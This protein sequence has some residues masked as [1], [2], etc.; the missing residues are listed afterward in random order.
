MARSNNL[1]AQLNL[2]VSLESLGRATKFTALD[3]QLTEGQLKVRITVTLRWGMACRKIQIQ[4]PWD[5]RRL[6][7]SNCRSRLASGRW[8]AFLR[9]LGHVLGC[10]NPWLATIRISEGRTKAVKVKSSVGQVQNLWADQLRNKHGQ[11][12]HYLSRIENFGPLRSWIQSPRWHLLTTQERGSMVSGL[13]G[14][15]VDLYWQ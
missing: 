15:S 11:E 14:D 3:I 13:S 5:Q 2:A 9:I 1:I 10:Q 12:D 6:D 7:T 8:D 4:N